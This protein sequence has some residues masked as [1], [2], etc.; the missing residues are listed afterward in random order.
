MNGSPGLADILKSNISISEQ[1]RSVI[2]ESPVPGL[3]LMTAGNCATSDWRLLQLPRMAEVLSQLKKEF[4]FI[5]VDSPPMLQ[6]TDGRILAKLADSVLLVCRA[7]HT[8]A[9]H[10]I[11]AA[12]LLS[13]DGSRLSGTILNVW[14]VK[15]EDPSYFRAY[16]AHYRSRS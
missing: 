6:L 11:E 7:G 3:S 8:R 9:D 5:L 10:A 4:D 12:R 2:R 15:A 16:H 13:Y 1:I 14:D